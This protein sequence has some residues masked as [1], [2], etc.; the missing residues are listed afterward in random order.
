[1]PTFE[2]PQDPSSGA[3]LPLPFLAAPPIRVPA[4]GT[5]HT[6]VDLAQ[7]K[8]YSEGTYLLNCTVAGTYFNAHESIKV[9]WR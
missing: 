9:R 8:A 1:V 7:E 6:C 2:G 4:G 3:Q 5:V